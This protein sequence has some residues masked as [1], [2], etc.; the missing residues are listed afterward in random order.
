MSGALRHRL[1]KWLTALAIFCVA[2]G[3]VFSIPYRNKGID[4]NANNDKK[5]YRNNPI[6]HRRHLPPN[7]KEKIASYNTA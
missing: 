6:R 5:D 7:V 2:I 4:N 3:I 1:G